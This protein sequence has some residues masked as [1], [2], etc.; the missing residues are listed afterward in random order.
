MN[1]SHTNEKDEITSQIC[2]EEVEVK[3][4]KYKVPS[5][6]SYHVSMESSN[7]Y[8]SI[9]RF[10]DDEKNTTIGYSWN[11]LTKSLKH[12]KIQ[13]YVC[14][15]TNDNKLSEDETVMLGSYLTGKIHS[16]QLSTSK[17]VTY[18]KVTGNI[19]D[20]P[21]LIFNRSTR[22]LTMKNVEPKHMTTLKKLKP[23]LKHTTDI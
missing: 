7:S 12:K 2:E 1:E 21:G 15:Y 9:Q 5:K 13:E 3:Q 17:A 23:I 18:D 6:N 10:L 20:I 4:L 22:H 11:K 16:G 14:K 19:M 8:D